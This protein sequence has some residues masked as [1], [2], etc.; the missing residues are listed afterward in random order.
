[1]VMAELVK[2][3][4]ERKQRPIAR[5]VLDYFPLALAEIAYVS[6]VGNEQHNPGQ[7]MHW[8]K[9]KSPDH[10]DCI[11]R[12]LIE[13]GTLD[14]D[15]LRHT[16]KVAWRALAL[17]QIEL[18]G[19]T[20]ST[21]RIP[22]LKEMAMETCESRGYGIGGVSLHDA[23]NPEPAPKPGIEFEDRELFGLLSGLGCGGEVA[24]A[25]I[26]GIRYAAPYQSRTRKED[27][28][29]VYIAGPMRGKSNL[30]FPQF[31]AARDSFR[32]WGYN[33]ISPADIDRAAGDSDGISVKQATAQAKDYLYRDFYAIYL[34]MH[35]GVKGKNAVA[36]LPGWEESTG[37]L[38][39]FAIARW[40]GLR[41][42]DA[43]TGDTLRATDVDFR[44]LDLSIH[45]HLLSLLV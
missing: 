10:A 25:I 3:S 32:A 42:L 45:D 20:A 22:S 11:A 33:V 19:S 17:L 35:V 18:E 24:C 43:T 7:E 13:R 44:K 21:P 34:M 4:V 1:M 38:A 15:G 12:H 8:A 6:F 29:Y 39:E 9:D 14:T 26:K 5:G 23:A 28:P 27:A 37:A 36:F 30:N 31:D 41:I 16:A 40:L 2:D